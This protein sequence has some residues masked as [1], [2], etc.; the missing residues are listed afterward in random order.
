MNVMD[1][2]AKITDISRA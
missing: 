1:S 2:D